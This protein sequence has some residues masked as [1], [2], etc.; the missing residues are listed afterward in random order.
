MMGYGAGLLVLG[1]LF[2]AVCAVLLS[3]GFFYG[4]I[5][6]ML[7]LKTGVTAM[8]L[9]LMRQFEN[10]DTVFF[11]INLGLSRRRM[12]KTVLAVDYLVWAAIIVIILLTR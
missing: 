8:S 11:Y 12:L 3:M 9:Y 4:A 1:G 2:N 6:I 7:I 10:R 5:V